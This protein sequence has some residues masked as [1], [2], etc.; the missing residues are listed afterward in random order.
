MM[1]P[2]EREP[3]PDFEIDRKA[4]AIIWKRNGLRIV[5]P[6]QIAALS[7]IFA[8]NGWKRHFNAL[9]DAELRLSEPV[10]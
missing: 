7:D 9:L 10:Q 6:P 2:D 1:A 4:Q 8:S 5:H 3:I